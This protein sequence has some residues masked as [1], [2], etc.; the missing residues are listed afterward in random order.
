MSTL[1]ATPILRLCSGLYAG[2]VFDV[3]SALRLGR[4]PYNEVSINDPAV[5]RY[6]CWI[7]LEEGQAMIEDLAS[8]NGTFLNGERVQKRVFLKNGDRIRMG[9]TEFVFGED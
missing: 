3:R 1:L 6:H 4:H 5:S 7:T 2:K 8:S 9:G